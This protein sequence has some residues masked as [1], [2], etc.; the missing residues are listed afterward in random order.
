MLYKPSPVAGFNNNLDILWPYNKNM[1]ISMYL[2]YCF[3]EL[4]KIVINRNY[5]DQY[6]KVYEMKV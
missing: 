1:N 6:V 4:N 2:P 5:E 3:K